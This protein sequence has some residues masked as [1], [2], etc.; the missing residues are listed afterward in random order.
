A[1]D[2]PLPDGPFAFGAAAML[3]AEEGHFSLA[4]RCAR[5]ALAFQADYPPALLALG[6]A[7]DGLGRTREAETSLCEALALD[8]AYGRLYGRLFHRLFGRPDAVGAMRELERL[9][10][11]GYPYSLLSRMA[12]G[13][14]PNIAVP[15]AG[16]GTSGVLGRPS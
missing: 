9:A 14:F 15:D 12:L 8:P 4:E 2:L 1:V 3:L 13:R 16:V 11:L 10:P 7:L 5:H 6:I